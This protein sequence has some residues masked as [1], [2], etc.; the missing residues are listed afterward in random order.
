MLAKLCAG[1]AANG[2][3]GDV[4]GQVGGHFAQPDEA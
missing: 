1:K 3:D 4:G 2:Q